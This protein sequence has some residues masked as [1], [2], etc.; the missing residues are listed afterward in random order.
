MNIIKW[1][2]IIILLIQPTL[3][4]EISG[5]GSPSAACGTARVAGSIIHEI[6][7]SG[8]QG[9]SVTLAYDDQ[10]LSVVTDLQGGFE[11]VELCEGEHI[12]SID[13]GTI[14]QGLELQTVTLPEDADV[15]GSGWE[16]DIAG[17]SDDLQVSF[18]FSGALSARCSLN[19]EAGCN[20]V[21][22]PTEL[23]RCSKKV[24]SL[25]M[26]W[27]GSGDV[28][29]VA[30]HGKTGDPVIAQF[31]WVQPGDTVSVAAMQD[32][33]DDVEWEVFDLVTG[34]SIGTSRFH[35]ACD[36]EEMDGPEDCGALQ[37]NGKDNKD[38]RINSWRL[39]GLVDASGELDC[40]TPVYNESC[41]FAPQRVDCDV[42]D[43]LFTLTFIYEGST[44]EASHHHQPDKF[45][46]E[47][48]ITAGESAW[49]RVK[50]QGEF[51]VLPGEVFSVAKDGSDL[52][53]ELENSGGRQQLKI[54]T[55]C[56]APLAVNDRYGAL[57]LGAINGRGVV[58]PVDFEY[59]VTNLG[60]G[61]IAGLE[62]GETLP[63]LADTE[64]DDVN[65]ATLVLMGSTWLL[66]TAENTFIA[67]GSD[68]VGQCGADADMVTSVVEPL[69]TCDVHELA[70]ELHDK[71]IRWTLA[72]GTDSP[73]AVETIQVSWP[74]AGGRLK[75][76]LFD[77]DKFFDLD[78]EA[79][80]F[81]I[82]ASVFEGELKKRKL[83]RSDER[84]LKIKF[85]EDIPDGADGYSITVNF[86]QG[87][88]LQW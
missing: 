55:S 28:R 82:D 14:P 46:C 9:V 83:R 67:V 76:A 77:G 29:V 65:G 36:D 41:V 86:E 61:P 8:I 54:H 26:T 3:K 11:F 72:N 18:V 44:C 33:A 70:R 42:I 23:Y 59:Q 4:A 24:H 40:S 19:V 27:E 35:L 78:I 88:Q 25:S 31:D 80:P 10:Q 57:R 75:E 87:C 21:S 30:H 16:I 50:D 81:V 32:P 64:V 13:F 49:I 7:G 56:S 63:T 53:L 85:D 15:A 5:S 6:S 69:A 79:G 66:E 51:S 84:V 68:S 45:Q 38:D 60:D 17:D 48:S 22:L 43:K 73:A 12:L 47:G 58:T 74:A 37:G 1:L 20:V 2:P 71:E 62:V 39:A 34:L 52:E